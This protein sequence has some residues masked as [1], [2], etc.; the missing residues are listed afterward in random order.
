VDSVSNI[1]T[2]AA[3]NQKSTRI[4]AVSLSVPVNV[5]KWWTMQ[6]NI[7]G[8]NRVLSGTLSGSPIKL[9]QS[10]LQFNSQQSFVLPKGYSLELSGFYTTKTIFGVY[11]APGRGSLNAGAQKKLP[12]LKG[13]IRF[14]ATNIL[15]SMTFKPFINF[16]ERNLVV[17]S[18]LNFT[19]P[20]FTFTYTHNFGN[21]KMKG[22]RDRATGAE[23]E[24]NRV[25]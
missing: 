1:E 8:N 13:N 2:L 19:Y 22:T 6:Y 24:K 25:Q 3:A 23:E 14:N 12:K 4:W 18:R 10:Y 16:P 17:N 21:S 11:T 5:S 20:S 15:N 9:K 7:V